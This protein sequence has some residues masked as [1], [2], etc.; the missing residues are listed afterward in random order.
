MAIVAALSLVAAS[1]AA[2]PLVDRGR[3]SLEE[4]DFAGALAAL[5]EAEAQ[6]DLTRADLVL[7]LETRALVHRALGEEEPTDAALRSLASIDPDHR[8]APEVTPDVVQRFAQLRDAGPGPLALEVEEA[9]SPGGI[10]LRAEVRGDVASMVHAVTVRARVN[11]GTWREGEGRLALEAPPG[12]R[13]EWYAVAYGTG[14][15]PVAQRGSESATRHARVPGAAVTPT[16]GGAIDE[17]ALGVGIAAGIAALV[18]A[19]V[20]LGVVLTSGDQALT[21]VEGPSFPAL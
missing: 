9:P 5:D 15:A 20:I 6:G 2:H 3:A 11:E 21:R 18:A 10:T 4:A 8:F 16:Q 14:G 19:A 17:V 13:I 12:A 1:A 7:L